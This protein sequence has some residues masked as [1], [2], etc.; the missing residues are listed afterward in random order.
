VILIRV[1][2]ETLVFQL[3]KREKLL[4]LEVLRDYPQVPPT[5]WVV[6]KSTGLPDPATSQ[7]LLDEALAEQRVENKRQLRTLVNDPHRWT[8]EHQHWLLRLSQ[9][10]LEWMLQILNDIRVGSWVPLGSPEEWSEMIPEK[11]SRLW[12]ME[13]AGAFQMAFLHAME[14]PAG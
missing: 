12:V 2:K 10:E 7:R 9:A 4:L 5:H 6:S 1:D 8:Q 13:L 3:A 14:R 11:A